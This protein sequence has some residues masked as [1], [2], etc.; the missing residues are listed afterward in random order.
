MVAPLLLQPP[1]VVSVF[2]DVGCH[3]ISQEVA[4]VCCVTHVPHDPV[5][6]QHLHMEHRIKTVDVLSEVLA[7]RIEQ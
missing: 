4:Q 6:V 3:W 5:S 2:L 1:Q 7:F